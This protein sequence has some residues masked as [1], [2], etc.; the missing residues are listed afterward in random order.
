MGE[1]DPPT[2]LEVNILMR[3]PEKKQRYVC[4]FCGNYI[5]GNCHMETKDE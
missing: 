3:N 2:F 1:V 4:D 5:L